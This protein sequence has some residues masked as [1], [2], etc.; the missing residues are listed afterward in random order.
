M[1]D[2]RKFVRQTASHFAYSFRRRQEGRAIAGRS[3]MQSPPGDVWT[4]IRA[5]DDRRRRPMPSESPAR[6]RSRRVKKAVFTGFSAGDFQIAQRQTPSRMGRRLRD[7][8]PGGDLLLHENSHYHRRS[9]V[10]LPSSGWDRVGPQ[11]YSRQGK[12]WN[13]AWSAGSNEV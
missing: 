12:G 9:C 13:S 11:R 3:G 8:A 7:K 2:H 5:P 4:S 6:L 1:S 10:S